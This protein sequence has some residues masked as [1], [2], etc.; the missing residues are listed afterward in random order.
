MHLKKAKDKVYIADFAIQQFFR[1]ASVRN[2][3]CKGK[4]NPEYKD[5]LCL[6][7]YCFF[8]KTTM[9]QQHLQLKKTAG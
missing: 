9:L 1:F 8:W 2:S 5:R 3:C 7:T 6:I 4:I